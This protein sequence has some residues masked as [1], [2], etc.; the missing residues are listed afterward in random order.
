MLIATVILLIAVLGASIFRYD[1]ALSA[2]K[3]DLQ[4]TA[5]RTALLLCESWRAVHDSNEFDP[6]QLVDTKLG[7]VLAIAPGSLTYPTPDGFT[8]LGIYQ[9][10]V[11]DNDGVG[12]DVRDTSYYAVLSYRDVAAGLRALN[13]TVVW[14]RRGSGQNPGTS[15]HLAKSFQLTTF[16]EN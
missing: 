4:A 5:A 1:S 15:P 13:V 16:V 8:T 12:D 14:D 9:V 10:G 11:G 2:R 6:T 7:S 3:A